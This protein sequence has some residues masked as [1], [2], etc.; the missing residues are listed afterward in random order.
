M[1]SWGSVVEGSVFGWVGMRVRGWGGAPSV[2]P[3]R[4]VP[5]GLPIGG[6]EARKIVDQTPCGSTGKYAEVRVNEARRLVSDV[7]CGELSNIVV[8]VRFGVGHGVRMACWTWSISSGPELRFVRGARRASKIVTFR[9]GEPRCHRST[10][11]AAAPPGVEARR[12]ASHVGV[13]SAEGHDGLVKA[14]QLVDRHLK[15]L[16]V[17]GE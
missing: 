4:G 16:G 2:G 9:F 17:A 7:S 3:G 12:R 13:C 8:L 11:L 1:G 10:P 15:H 5:L 14:Q 6:E